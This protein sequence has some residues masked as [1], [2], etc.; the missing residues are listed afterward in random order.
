MKKCAISRESQR[1]Y[2]RDKTFLKEKEWEKDMKSKKENI[3]DVQRT[4]I[5]ITLLAAAFITSMSTAEDFFP[6]KAAA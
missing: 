4:G 1:T 6:L 3:S 5:L 2:E